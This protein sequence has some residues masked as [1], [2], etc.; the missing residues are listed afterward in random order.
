MTR[1]NKVVLIGPLPNE[2]PKSIGG[3]STSFQIML[4]YF[5]NEG[6]SHK[7]IV[8][9]RFNVRILNLINVFLGA[10]VGSF[11]SRALMFNINPETY[12]GLYRF[13]NFLSEIMGKSIYVRFFGGDLYEKFSQLDPKEKL[14][15]ESTSFLNHKF[16]MQTKML[17]SKF[18]NT[19]KNVFWYPNYRNAQS[20]Q[21]GSKEFRK[22]FVF[23]SQV[24]QTKGIE[25]V[26]HAIRV[27]GDVVTIHIY[28]PVLDE[29]FQY[30]KKHTCYKGMLEPHKVH[31]TLA[32]YDVL[33][34]PTYH[35]GEG[36]PG[37]IIEGYSIGLPVI[38]TNWNAI[39]EIVI[40]GETGL[41][42]NPKSD[43]EIL[44]AIMSFNK[45]NYQKYSKASLEHFENFK[46]DN[47]NRRLYDI[48][49]DQE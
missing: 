9:N 48:L 47:V 25:Q 7:L 43:S 37:I 19:M 11:S 38:T 13:L 26:L 23:I 34:L 12:F 29:N 39:P 3:A 20:I 40:E 33:L 31:E 49:K 1:S 45:D 24:K 2:N 27:L 15:I 8:T 22:K 32:N 6:L 28:G 16:F 4:N 17:I 41:L 36:Y 35:T 10:L 46:S 42:I 18:D 14:N 30:L 21:R 5:R 44:A